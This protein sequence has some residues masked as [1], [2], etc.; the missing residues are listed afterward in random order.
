MLSVNA[1]RQFSA[2]LTG[3]LLGSGLTD[4]PLVSYLIFICKADKFYILFTFQID[5]VLVWNSV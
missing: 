5:P 1:N 4:E 3:L 2:G